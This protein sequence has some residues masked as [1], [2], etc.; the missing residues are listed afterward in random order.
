MNS[1][2]RSGYVLFALTFLLVGC[3]SEDRE[4]SRTSTA[5][6]LEGE[7]ERIGSAA[8]GS[9]KTLD[10]HSSSRNSQKKR[11]VDSTIGDHRGEAEKEAKNRSLSPGSIE[12][13][14]SDE[15]NSSN[16][17]SRRKKRDQSDARNL[18]AREKRQ[19]EDSRVIRHMLDKAGSYEDIQQAVKEHQKQVDKMREARK[20]GE[21]GPRMGAL[22]APADSD[23]NES[24]DGSK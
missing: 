15:A 18:S 13:S 4:D 6:L 7:A 2:L 9:E 14:V 11:R 24:G 20:R 1:V 22:V 12:S 10:R 19:R 3:E 16:I 23:T 21:G 17:K 8:P 5:P